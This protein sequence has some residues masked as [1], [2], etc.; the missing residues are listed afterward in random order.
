[1]KGDRNADHEIKSLEKQLA[2]LQERFTALEQKF[3]HLQE[4]DITATENAA[5]K[6]NDVSTN[7]VCNPIQGRLP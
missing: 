2:I 6:F 5:G 4:K 1:M 3:M 7:L